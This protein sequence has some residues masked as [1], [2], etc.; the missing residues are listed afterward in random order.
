MCHAIQS[1][2]ACQIVCWRAVNE[3]AVFASDE[4]MVGEV[5]IGSSPVQEGSAG[6][7]IRPGKV[8]RV[9]D[10]S[11]RASKYK[12]RPTLHGHTENIS[13]RDFMRIGIRAKSCVG[14][15]I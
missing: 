2:Q 1:I 13:R 7:R 12:W 8:L 9:E 14:L 3:P 6:L 11:A 5:D 4:E 15:R 10:Q